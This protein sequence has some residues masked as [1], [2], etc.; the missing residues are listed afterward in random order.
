[1][2][3]YV[4][5]AKNKSGQK[6]FKEVEAQTAE[7][8]RAI[9]VEA[10]YSELVLK[11]DEIMAAVQEGFPSTINVLGQ[12][13]KVTTEQ[14]LKYLD[15]P[16]LT[17]W[18]AV[19]EGISQSK[20]I[21]VLLPLLAA[22]SGYREHWGF[23]LLWIIGLLAWIAFLV[24][25][26][27]PLVYYRKLIM[28]SDWYRWSEVLSLVSTLQSMGRFSFIKVPATEMTRNRAKALAGMG[29]L[30]EALAEYKQCE[31]R[32]DCPTW[33]YNQFVGSLYTTAKQYDKGIESSLLSIGEKPT[34]TAWADLANRYARY[35]RDPVKAR[36]AM[37][38][39]D[40]SPMV[41][42]VKPFRIRCLGI[43]AYLEGDYLTAKGH[44]ETAIDMLEKAKGRPYRDG[45][46]SV[47]RAYLCCVLAKL[48]DLQG[49]KNCLA[50]SREY[51]VATEETDLLT[52]CCKLVGE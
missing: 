27:L 12:A 49:A 1:M 4:W 18:G 3:K 10:G 51:L 24:C 36:E 11:G 21:C 30:D 47:A 35:K 2:S 37:A 32:A 15:T 41:E 16:M 31:G 43:I 9:L 33:L 19:R 23:A 46:L 28:A 26:S 29:R 50:L 52:E 44:L 20:L 6:V 8:S 14:R 38:E 25:V 39:A 45:H 7:E 17:F 48:G 5:T 22:Y 40:K 13:V 42:Q 34:P